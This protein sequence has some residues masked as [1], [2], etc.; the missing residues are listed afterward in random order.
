[1]KLRCLTDSIRLRLRKSDI[2]LLRENSELTNSL[3]FPGQNNLSYGIRLTNENHSSAF[4]GN[5]LLVTLNSQLATKWMDSDIVS[6]AFKLTV[7]EG[8]QLAILIEKDFPCKHTG[9]DFEDTFH[10]LQPDEFK[11]YKKNK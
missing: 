1:M 8:K 9:D 2:Q 11:M 6:L 3:N 7:D 4:D 10:E 5:L